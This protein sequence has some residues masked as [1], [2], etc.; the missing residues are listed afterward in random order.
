MTRM[1]RA[2]EVGARHAW[3]GV[4]RPPRGGGSGVDRATG[5]V[6]PVETSRKTMQ[7]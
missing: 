4:K 1:A 7:P 3:G 2:A 5:P 6:G